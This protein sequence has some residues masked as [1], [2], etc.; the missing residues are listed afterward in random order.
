MYNAIPVLHPGFHNLRT[1]KYNTQLSLLL[2]AD[3]LPCRFQA[4]VTNVTPWRRNAHDR[5]L[6]QHDLSWPKRP[7]CDSDATA[8]SWTLDHAVREGF[9]HRPVHCSTAAP[10]QQCTGG[11]CKLFT[12]THALEKNEAK[13]RWES[14]YTTTR[15]TTYSAYYVLL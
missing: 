15:H 4:V 13:V 2:Y 7:S 1:S 5:A 8:L 3:S 9:A 14:Y 10:Q 12:F 6:R 11:D